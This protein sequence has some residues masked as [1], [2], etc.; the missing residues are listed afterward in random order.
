MKTMKMHLIYLFLKN[1]LY[2]FF[3]KKTN[4]NISTFLLMN[5]I[6]IRILSVKCFTLTSG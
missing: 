2:D 5:K 1:N 3:F 4:A 6:L